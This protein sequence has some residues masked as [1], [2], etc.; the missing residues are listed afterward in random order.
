M[1]SKCFQRS[2]NSLHSALALSDFISSSENLETS[3]LGKDF[4]KSA[5]IS[6]SVSLLPE[7]LFNI[8]GSMAHNRLKYTS[9]C[10]IALRTQRCSTLPSLPKLSPS[11]ARTDWAA[12]RPSA[13][14]PW[15][16][17]LSDNKASLKKCYQARK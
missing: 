5:K 6:S 16:L 9:A 10:S 17:I 3:K 2:Q 8:F 13:P 7:S 15:L 14:T 1:S 12:R 11:A 4:W